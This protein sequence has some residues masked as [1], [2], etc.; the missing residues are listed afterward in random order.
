M[1]VCRAWLTAAQWGIP[2]DQEREIRHCDG[3]GELSISAFADNPR[4]EELAQL[5][6]E[7]VHVG[8]SE[9]EMDLEEPT[10][11]TAISQALN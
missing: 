2:C 8:G 6:E 3:K 1:L 10:A 7:G 9:L 5:L 11:A 4:G